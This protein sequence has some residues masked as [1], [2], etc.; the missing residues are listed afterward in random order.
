LAQF[1]FGIF[2]IFWNGIVTPNMYD[3]I[4]KVKIDE[5]NRKTENKF[6]ETMF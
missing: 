3:L 6:M 5:N 4:K 2:K 1:S